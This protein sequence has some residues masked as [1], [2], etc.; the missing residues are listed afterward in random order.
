MMGERWCRAECQCRRAS[1]CRI[2]QSSDS[3]YWTADVWVCSFDLTRVFR[4]RFVCEVEGVDKAVDEA[5]IRR[6]RCNPAASKLPSKRISG[7]VVDMGWLALGKVTRVATVRHVTF[8]MSTASDQ[9]EYKTFPHVMTD[10]HLGRV[11]RGGL[12]CRGKMNI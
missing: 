4:I 10:W 8:A 5:Q 1:Y 11:S 12:K 3:V 7:A 9:Y 2:A 6:R